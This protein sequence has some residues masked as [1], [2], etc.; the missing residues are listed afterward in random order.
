MIPCEGMIFEDELCRAGGPSGNLRVT[1]FVLRNLD[2]LKSSCECFG[3]TIT[4]NLI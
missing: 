3:E 4:L 1:P 2:L